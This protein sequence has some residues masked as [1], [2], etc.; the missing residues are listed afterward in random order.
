[1]AI[2]KILKKASK[3]RNELRQIF[4]LLSILVVFQ[5]VMLIYSKQSLNI[6]LNETQEWYQK[7]TAERLAIS[8][9]TSLELLLV[10]LN[11]KQEMTH[12]EKRKIINSFNIIFSQQQIQTNVQ[13]VCLIIDYTG[14][15]IVLD[16]GE[17]IFDLLSQKKEIDIIPNPEYYE[18]L[19]RFEQIRETIKANEQIITTTDEENSFHVFVP[20]VP[21]GEFLGVFYMKTQPDFSIITRRIG[22]NY[23]TVTIIY[24]ILILIGLVGIYI[25]SARAVRERNIAQQNL[26]NEK[27]NHLKEQIEHEKESLF[28]KRIY[29]THH[30]AE[31]V[32]GFIKEDL[33]QLNQDN[34]EETKYRSTKYSN[35]VS[36]VIYDMKWY[37]PPLNTIRNPLFRTDL[38]EVINFIVDNIF[39]RISTQSDMFEFKLDLDENLP[40]I[41]IYEFV[42]WEILEPLIQNSIDH[43]GDDKVII[44]IET[45]YVKEEKITKIIVADNGPGISEHL[46][47][48]N[49]LGIKKIFMEDVSTKNLETRNSGYGCYIAY[50][51]ATQRCNWVLDAKNIVSGGSAFTIIIKN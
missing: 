12:A 11:L 1:M 41:G 37:D 44:R 9:S 20:F 36:R 42:V 29:H 26:F 40:R 24:S 6:F 13:Q 21:N 46:L 2:K 34:I 18:A 25:L 4:L 17:P 51:M 3:Y 38:N 8:T 5:I 15:T 27:E 23:N 10:N 39:L 43:A 14:K 32:M 35:F 45:K 30:K 31:K 22:S 16:N 50:Q 49:E 19:N 7:E 33:R 28:T 48:K 47:E